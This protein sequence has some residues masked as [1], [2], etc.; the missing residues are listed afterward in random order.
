M[1]FEFRA[2][3][4]LEG[5][6]ADF[7]FEGH[8]DDGVGIVVDDAV[9]AKALC[10]DGAASSGAVVAVFHA[11]GRFAADEEVVGDHGMIKWLT[12]VD[13]EAIT[14]FDH[15]VVLNDITLTEAVQ[16]EGLED[17]VEHHI[18]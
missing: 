10:I 7:A 8:A 12:G 6:T 3:K 5:P 18:A 9:I 15:G 17:D 4:R 2:G 1:L 11:F 16:F 14:G 13:A